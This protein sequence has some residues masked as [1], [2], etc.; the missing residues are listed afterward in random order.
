MDCMVPATVPAQK[1]GGVCP[2]FQQQ[3]LA[4]SGLT[5]QR[6]NMNGWAQT[7]FVGNQAPWSRVWDDL[8]AR[9][10]GLG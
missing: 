6:G 8:V 10:L 2:E 5:G 3:S 9:G 1:E 4:P 7:W